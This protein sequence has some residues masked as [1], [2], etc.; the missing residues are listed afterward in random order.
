[1][2]WS[3]SRHS[4]RAFTL[5]E[6]LVVIAI[7]GVLVGMLLPAVQAVRRAARQTA[8]LNKI[9]QIGL[10]CQ[11]YTSS[12]Q[13]FPPASDPSGDS[14]LVL[15]LAQLDNQPMADRNKLGDTNT[16]L[17]N[18]SMDIF[19]CPDTTQTDHVP[20]PTDTESGVAFGAFTTHYVGSAGPANDNSSPVGVGVRRTDATSSGDPVGLDGVFSPFSLTPSDPDEPV[21][22]MAKRGKSEADIR[23]GMSNTIAVGEISR[24]ENVTLMFFP[25][26]AGWA[27]GYDVGSTTATELGDVYAAKTVYEHPSDPT[28]HSTINGLNVS[29]NTHSFGSN[30]P[31]GANFGLADGS[32]HFLTEQIGI[33]SLQELVSINDGSTTSIDDF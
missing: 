18:S 19:I 26:R 15:L 2:S 6:L 1:M 24:S 29:F 28:M 3:H 5:V 32:T 21:E 23:D 11:N 17:S 9:K 27:W 8:C 30:H 14:F 20:S 31:G 16:Q 12:F 33:G 10:A 22:F 25:Q 7:I 4:R 13:R